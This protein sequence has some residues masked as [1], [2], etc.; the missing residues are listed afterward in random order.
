MAAL[1]QQAKAQCCQLTVCPSIVSIY[2]CQGSFRYPPRVQSASMLAGPETLICFSLTSDRSGSNRMVSAFRYLLRP[3][4]S[5]VGSTNLQT[6]KYAP[7][8]HGIIRRMQ[9]VNCRQSALQGEQWHSICLQ[10]SANTSGVRFPVTKYWPSDKSLFNTS[11]SRPVTGLT[12]WAAQQ[13]CENFTTGHPCLDL[14][15]SW[16]FQLFTTAFVS[17]LSQRC[18][19]Y[20]RSLAGCEARGNAKH[21]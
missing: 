16:H 11:C 10:S 13:T 18:Q 6:N 4:T 19:W 7:L 2:G 15:H 9:S 17:P 21:A 12:R 3:V 5:L 14:V 8:L 1:R 20:C